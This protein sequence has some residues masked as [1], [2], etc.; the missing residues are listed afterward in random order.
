MN[1]RDEHYMRLALDCARRAEAMGEVP[2]GAVLVAGDAVIAEGW[3]QPIS[4]CDPSAHAEML[5]LREG[6]RVLGNYRLLDTTMYITLEPCAMCVAAMVHAR[7]KR[8][9]YGATDPKTGM[10]VSQLNLFLHPAMN[11][12]IEVEGGVLAEECGRTLSGFFAARREAKRA[13]RKS[14]D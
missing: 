5:A 9:V 3:N 14:L 12:R 8:V 7:V 11:W 10:A 1:A 6:A 4:T 13:E 2:V